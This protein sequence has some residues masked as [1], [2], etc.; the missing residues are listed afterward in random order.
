MSKNKWGQH[1][2]IHNNIAENI[3]DTADVQNGDSILEIGP[4]RGIL[5]RALL[6]RGSQVIAIEV[7]PALCEKL[8]IEFEHEKR[9]TLIEQDIMKISPED[10]ARK[11]S[12]PSKV[13]ANLPYNIATPLLLR[14][15]LVRKAW[16]SLTIMVQL[17]VAE[18]ICASPD[19]GKIFGPL[20]LVGALGFE[21]KIIQIISPESFRPAPKVDSSVIQLLPH[22]SSLTHEEEKHFLK[23][24][25]LLFQQRR[26]TLL[27]GIRRHFPE[28]FQN[29]EN[30]L[31]EKYGLSRPE[32]LDFSEWMVLFRDYLQIRKNG[33]F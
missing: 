24:S 32:N 31:R 19:S 20:S 6:K 1:F 2:L 12:T 22:S 33:Y 3:V 21:R 14:M 27:N 28:W 9:F 10:L 29:C 26:K 13:V 11:V 15:L 4:G 7:D 8:R 17:E 5:T 16:Q 25:H 30:S 23:W 18:R